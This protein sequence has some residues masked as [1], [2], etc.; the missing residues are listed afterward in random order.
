[1]Y[2]G[3]GRDGIGRWAG[4]GKASLLDRTISTVQQI[5]LAARDSRCIVHAWIHAAKV[6]LTLPLAFSFP[7]HNS[8][9]LL[10]LGRLEPFPDP[11]QELIAVAAS[12]TLLLVAID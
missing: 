10:L 6:L 8:S 5:S 3:G 11:L 12:D 7:F 1:M 2:I 4:G 9:L